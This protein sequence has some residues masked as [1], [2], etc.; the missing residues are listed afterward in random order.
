MR[1]IVVFTMLLGAV[2][3]A[4]TPAVPM[5]PT[6]RVAHVTASALA[7]IQ[8]TATAETTRLVEGGTYSVNQRT[9]RLEAPLA[10]ADITE[11]YVIRE[12]SGTLV[13]GGK[14]V[15]PMTGDRGTDIQGGE[16]R[17]VKSGDVVFI[18]AK[19]PHWFREIP[20][21]ITFLNIRFET[22]PASASGAN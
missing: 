15:G 3:F 22:K 1:I 14:L 19:L 10:H 6:D 11:V 4:Q 2:A 12:G 20:D 5:T 9:L 13:T 18:P 7:E 8:R 21:S 16:S 17:V